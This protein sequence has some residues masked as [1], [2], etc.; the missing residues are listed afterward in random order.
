MGMNKR[1]VER[2]CATGELPAVKLRKKWL[3]NKNLLYA[4]LGLENEE[5][6]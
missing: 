4:R 6:T 5:L 3:I 1:T 2:M